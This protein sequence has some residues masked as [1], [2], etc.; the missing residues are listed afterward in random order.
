MINVGRECDRACRTAETV[1]PAK[2]YP[3]NVA[4]VRR[5]DKG[6][7]PIS[8]QPCLP[9]GRGHGSLAA[10]AADPPTGEPRRLSAPLLFAIL[11]LPPVFVWLLLRP[12]YSRDVRTGAFLYAFLFPALQLATLLLSRSGAG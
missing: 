7:R 3:A 8:E 5:L 1:P 10:M 12:G 9:A 4:P 6:L 2:T 11:I